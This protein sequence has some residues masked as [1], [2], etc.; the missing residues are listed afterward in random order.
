M[1][2]LRKISEDNQKLLLRRIPLDDYE[3]AVNAAQDSLT[4]DLNQFFQNVEL[5]RDGVFSHTTK[6]SIS[7][8]GIGGQLDALE[9]EFTDDDKKLFTAEAMRDV[10]PGFTIECFNRVRINRNNER[11]TPLLEFCRL[12]VESTP[13]QPGVGRTETF[14]L[15]FPMDKL[16]ERFIGHLIRRHAP[17]LGLNRDQVVLQSGGQKTKYLVE[18][19]QGNGKFKLI[20]DIMFINRPEWV[21]TIVDT[22]WKI[23]SP[24]SKDPNNDVSQGDMYQ[25][26]AYATRFQSMDNVLLYPAVEGVERRDFHFSD[27]KVIRKIRVEMVDMNRDLAAEWKSFVDDLRKILRTDVGTTQEMSESND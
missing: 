8:L 18:T 23:L 27:G 10:F 17:E 9:A 5:Y 2:D 22:K 24:N 13:P 1:F 11:F 21:T 4:N 6:E 19:V 3:A 12:I 25:M 15:L 14:A 20:P 7:T 26:F 16:F